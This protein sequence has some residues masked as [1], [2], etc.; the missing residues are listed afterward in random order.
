MNVLGPVALGV[1]LIG[2]K[3][4][5]ANTTA[6]AS[7]QP[8]VAGSLRETVAALAEKKRRPAGD[9]ARLAEETISF[10]SKPE[11]IEELKKK[12]PDNADPHAPWRNMVHDALSG[13]DEGERLNAKAADW[14]GL[15]ERLKKLQ[16]PPS[17]SS[18]PEKK[19]DRKDK[20]KSQKKDKKDPGGSGKDKQEPS[21]G[22][23]Q[24]SEEKDRGQGQEGKGE[25]QS[26]L[27]QSGSGQENPHPENNSQEKPEGGGSAAKS[28]A[29]NHPFTQ[30]REP[31]ENN[32]GG[33]SM[34]Q[35]GQGET[36]G[37]EKFGQGESKPE[38]GKEADRSNPSPEVGAEDRAMRKVGGGS[39]KKEEAFGFGDPD[40]QSVSRLQQ[41]KQADSPALIQ[42]N[43]DPEKKHQPRTVSGG[44]PW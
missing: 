35:P 12:M 37:F 44:K 43:L 31:A 18:Q 39:G 42:Q 13:V 25:S 38:T 8:D 23:G 32:Q 20:N 14:P 6:H 41:V 3:A 33:A 30:P 19:K 21:S 9:Y 28:Q 36:A 17:P 16:P 22:G 40:P 34:D 2:W 1:V 27:R 10:G 26:P 15:R 7:L 5:G 11:A 29:N 24:Q 4:H